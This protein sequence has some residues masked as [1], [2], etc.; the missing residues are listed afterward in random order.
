LITDWMARRWNCATFA[1]VLGM[2][3]PVP[4][5]EA[6]DVLLRSLSEVMR[7]SG[8]WTARK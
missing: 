1:R 2:G 6:I 4:T 8:V 5:L 3:V 7:Y